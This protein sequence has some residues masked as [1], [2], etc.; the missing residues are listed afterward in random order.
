MGYRVVH[1]EFALVYQGQRRVGSRPDGDSMWFKPAKP[2]NLKGIGG[3]D[4]ELNAGGYAQL[5]FEGIDALELHYGPNYHQAE[6]PAL[7]ARDFLLEK[8]GYLGTL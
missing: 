1:G 5:R 8:A 7:A 2:A 6:S 4:A 3:R